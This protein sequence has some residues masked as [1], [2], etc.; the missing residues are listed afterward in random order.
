MNTRKQIRLQNYDYSENG[1]YFITICTKD[2]QNVLCKSVG[3]TNG[4]PQN[5][6]LYYHKT[7]ELSEYGKITENAIKNITTH[8]PMI[9]VDKYVI[10]P[11]TFI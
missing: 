6:L 2:K 10:M 7:F 8:Y 3:T 4:R 1:L 5:E 11:K 9:N